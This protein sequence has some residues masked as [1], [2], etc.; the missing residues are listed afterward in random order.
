M[1][2]CV[3]LHKHTEDEI[4]FSGQ[5]FPRAQ[6]VLLTFAESQGQVSALCAAVGS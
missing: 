1:W 5:Y 6:L 4:F 2:S 3:A